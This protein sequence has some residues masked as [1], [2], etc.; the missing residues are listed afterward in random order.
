MIAMLIGTLGITA[1]CVIYQQKNGKNLLLWKLISDI[2]WFFHYLFL[3]AYSGSAIALIGVFRELVF[4]KENQKGRKSLFYLLFFISITV[5]SAIFTWKG[6]ISIFPAIA[7]I[8]SIIG[9]WKANPE[10]SRVLAFPVSG[11]M[12][13]YDLGCDSY[14][15]IANEVL[16]LFAATYAIIYNLYKRK[17]DKNEN[18][19]C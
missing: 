8:I 10:L 17:V 15:G 7:S 5:F 19:C 4:Y 3:G 14:V 2:L 1:N 11:L 12:L 13:T 18:R 16:T 9:F 6:V